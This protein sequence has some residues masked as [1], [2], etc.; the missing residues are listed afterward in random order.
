[1]YVKYAKG[2]DHKCTEFKTVKICWRC[3]EFAAA[4]GRRLCKTSVQETDSERD[5]CFP[6]GI[7]K[8]KRRRPINKTRSRRFQWFKTLGENVSLAACTFTRAEFRRIGRYDYIAALKFL[9][10][11]RNTVVRRVP[12]FSMAADP[13]HSRQQMRLALRNARKYSTER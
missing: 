6:S 8:S 1:M 3:F 10:I 2:T 11:A 12:I 5:C 13:S 7:K 4:I 9:S